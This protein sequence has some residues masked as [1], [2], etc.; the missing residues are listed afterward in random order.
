[1]S[2]D[3]YAITALGLLDGQQRLETISRNAANERDV[4]T[5]RR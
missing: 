2:H 3:L 1:M 5:W 4:A